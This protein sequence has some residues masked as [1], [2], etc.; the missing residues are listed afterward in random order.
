M[1]AK[2]AASPRIHGTYT[3]LSV[4][5]ARLRQGA[6]HDRLREMYSYRHGIAGDTC[7]RWLYNNGC[8]IPSVAERT[9]AQGEGEL[10]FCRR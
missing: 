8:H 1:V 7:A 3:D 4:T 5:I 6:I 9:K 2:K 10:H